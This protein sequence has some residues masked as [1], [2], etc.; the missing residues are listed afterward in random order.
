MKPARR[1]TLQ[2]GSPNYWH[3]ASWLGSEKSNLS[4]GRWPGNTGRLGGQ[5]KNPAGCLDGRPLDSKA[6]DPLYRRGLVATAQRKDS[7]TR[8]SGILLVLHFDPVL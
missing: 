5:Q 2:N 7:I 1:E 4:S 6:V 8:S 3:F